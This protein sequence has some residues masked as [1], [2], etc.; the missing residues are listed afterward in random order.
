MCVGFV[1]ACKAHHIARPHWAR[2]LTLAVQSGQIC[3][4][5]ERIVVHSSIIHEFSSQLKAA[6]EKIFGSDKPA[7]ILV[8]PAGVRKTKNLLKDAISKGGK[9]LAGDLDAKE[10]SETRMRPIIVENVTKDMDLYYTE[11]FGPSV[12]LISVESE[13]EAV[14]VANDTEY[15]LSAAV[16]TKDLARGLRVARRIESG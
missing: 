3:M 8:T 12:G 6:T 15:G 5:T 4:A 11:S 2:P 13:D 10:D 7:P 1:L 14:E 16:F 9:V